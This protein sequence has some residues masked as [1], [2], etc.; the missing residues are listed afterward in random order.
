[1][2]RGLAIARKCSHDE[3][4]WLTNL[5]PGAAPSTDDEARAVFL[6]LG[7]NDAKALCFAAFFVSV[8]Y[9]FWKEIL[10][11]ELLQS[12]SLGYGLAQAWVAENAR[13]LSDEKRLE[14]GKLA[15]AQGEPA[16]LVLLGRF[17]L[18]TH[19]VDAMRL[20]K[21]AAEKG[22]AEAQYLYAEN[23]FRKGDSER[24]TWLAKAARNGSHSTLWNWGS[25]FFRGK[26]QQRKRRGLVWR[27]PFP[28]PILVT[29]D[30]PLVLL[31]EIGSA[32]SACELLATALSR[33]GRTEA[34]RA[35]SFYNSCLERVTAGIHA[36]TQVGRRK[37]IPRDVRLLI[38]R[39]M[40]ESKVEWGKEKK[41]RPTKKR[42]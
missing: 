40:W 26:E 28:D 2:E 10:N 29:D 32:M 23:G 24:Y 14:F 13:T 33:Q 38:S 27:N 42:K 37:R 30:T 31:F 20:F 17:L 3:A 9:F 5:F 6:S 16:G 11:G 12:A 35:V 4:K 18:G 7:P 21:E 25:Q 1:M 19:D 34:Y 41:K 15:A 22:H 36:W 8:D 39:K